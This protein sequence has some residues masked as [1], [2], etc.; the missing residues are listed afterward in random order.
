MCVNLDGKQ[1]CINNEQYSKEEY[2]E[3]VTAYKKKYTYNE[4]IA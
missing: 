1:Y 4:L 3:R 2:N